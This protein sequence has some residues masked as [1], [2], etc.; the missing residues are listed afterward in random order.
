MKPSTHL[1]VC[2]RFCVV[3]LVRELV[4][5]EAL[6]QIYSTCHNIPIRVFPVLTAQRHCGPFDTSR[7]MIQ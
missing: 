4:Y 6:F 5:C 7:L 2:G 1:V 3:S